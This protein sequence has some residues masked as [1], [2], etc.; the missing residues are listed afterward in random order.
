MDIPTKGKVVDEFCCS[1]ICGDNLISAS[2]VARLS[3]GA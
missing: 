3:I 2:G 1:C